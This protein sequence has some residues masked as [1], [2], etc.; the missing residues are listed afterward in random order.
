MAGLTL[1]AN[2]VWTLAGRVVYA[3]SQWGMIIALARFGTLEDVGT[4][5]LALAVTAPLMMFANLQLRNLYATDIANQFDFTTYERV[6]RVS[7]LL[8]MVGAA[9]LA[10]GYLDAPHIAWA[11]ALM[12]LAKTLQLLVEVRQGVYQRFGR[13]DRLGQSLTARGGLGLL[14]L[15]VAMWLCRDLHVAMLAMIGT[16]AAVLFLFDLPVSEA[17]RRA[18]TAT[19]RTV[20]RGAGLRLFW[21]AAP[22]GFVCLLD[23]VNQ[24]VPRYFIEAHDG[25]MALGIYAPMTYVITI[26]ATF[27]YA[28]G[29]PSAPKLAAH[30]FAG[31]GRSFSRLTLRLLATGAIMGLAG[32]LFAVVCGRW[33]LDTA[34]GPA[35]A[36]HAELFVWVMF[37]GG[38]Q[39]VMTLSMYVLTATRRLALQLVIYASSTAVTAACSALL[40]P[41]HGLHGAALASV[42]GFAV[43]T[44][45]AVAASFRACSLIA[46]SRA[47]S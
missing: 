8:G 5:S 10:L 30:F 36:E 33:F 23:S 14:A 17:I 2:V 37:S 24:N 15:A 35:Y 26:G 9:S 16:W 46:A 19:S 7:A 38:L 12:A 21:L 20:E 41:A 11:I 3:A 29:A 39:F 27:V 22:M 13:M 6:R 4:F 18:H 42:A 28:M 1:R 40:V 32:V 31:D 34:Y 45:L 43:G 44:I 25:A 47:R